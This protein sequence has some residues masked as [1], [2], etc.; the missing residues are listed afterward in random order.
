VEGGGGGGGGVL[1]VLIGGMGKGLLFFRSG[2]VR[3]FKYLFL[4]VGGVGDTWIYPKFCMFL[5]IGCE[6]MF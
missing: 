2:W 4:V 6:F 5:V 3:A 1:G